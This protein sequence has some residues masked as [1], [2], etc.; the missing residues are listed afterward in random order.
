MRVRADAS[1]VAS[2]PDTSQIIGFSGSKERHHSRR[3]A[4]P[5]PRLSPLSRA[6]SPFSSTPRSS[7]TL[8]DE[9]SEIS[10]GL[11]CLTLDKEKDEFESDAAESTNELL[12]EARVERKRIAKSLQE[13]HK[14]AQ[15]TAS[16]PLVT[17]QSVQIGT[18]FSWLDQRRA[19]AAAERERKDA[20]VADIERNGESCSDSSGRKQVYCF[21]K[22][23]T[24]LEDLVKA[25]SISF[26]LARKEGEKES[27]V[28]ER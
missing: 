12:M 14:D 15:K 24:Q 1:S 17:P 13:V 7:N 10:R 16:M 2:S 23:K 4:S 19:A 6:S 3:R 28:D 26:G 27:K 8:N 5:A 18:S 22:N 25:S 20:N 21:G 9:E 11:E